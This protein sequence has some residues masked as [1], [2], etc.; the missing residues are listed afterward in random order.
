MQTK[1]DSTGSRSVCTAQW[2]VSGSYKNVSFLSVWVTCSPP[3]NQ[4]ITKNVIF[5]LFSAQ[6][7]ILTILPNKHTLK[8]KKRKK[9][10]S[11][12]NL[13]LILFQMI[14]YRPQIET[15]NKGQREKRESFP[16]KLLSY[17]GCEIFRVCLD[18]AYLVKLKNYY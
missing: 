13:C 4:I 15:I 9:N 2:P 18:T 16:R 7:S 17:L 1:E 10:A 6:F 5:P 14:R 3:S 11:Q 12:R 8:G